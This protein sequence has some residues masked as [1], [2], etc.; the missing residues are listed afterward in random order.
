MEDVSSSIG[1]LEVENMFDNT[2]EFSSDA[3]NHRSNF[4]TSE[5]VTLQRA[6]HEIDK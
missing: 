1:Y 4:S 2:N 5:C 3:H 6:M